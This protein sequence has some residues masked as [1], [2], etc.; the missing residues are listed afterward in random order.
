[1]NLVAVAVMLTLVV[2]F[3]GALLYGLSA[4]LAWLVALLAI[5]SVGLFVRW[6]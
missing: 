3:L 2:G 1:M 6:G 4:G 5:L